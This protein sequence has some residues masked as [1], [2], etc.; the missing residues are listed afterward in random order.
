MKA[1]SSDGYQ[2]FMF[3]TWHIPRRI[4]DRYRRIVFSELRFHHIKRSTI[5]RQ[6]GIKNMTKMNFWLNGKHADD[7]EV[8]QAGDK[9]IRWHLRT[10][11]FSDAGGLRFEG[12]T[13]FTPIFQ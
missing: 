2:E 11:G 10:K 3:G 8:I 12:L 5:A 1:K 4:D 6:L 7:L 13:K 9:L